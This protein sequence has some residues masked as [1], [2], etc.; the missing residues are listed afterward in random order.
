MSFGFS[1]PCVAR[2]RELET[3]SQSER[4]YERIYQGQELSFE[5]ELR[6]DLVCRVGLLARSSGGEG[7]E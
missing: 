3:I 4:G 6:G 1:A 2:S 5:V 7:A